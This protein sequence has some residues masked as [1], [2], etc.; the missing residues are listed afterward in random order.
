MP[1]IF[2][3]TVL[4]VLNIQPPKGWIQY[5]Y[6]YDDIKLCQQYI[7]HQKK[8][9]ILSVAKHY[10]NRLVSIETFECMTREE[11][12]KRNTALGH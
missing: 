4:V 12:V 10:R 11:A 5:T 6:P 1:T 8:A 3:V 2:F 9:I 7:E